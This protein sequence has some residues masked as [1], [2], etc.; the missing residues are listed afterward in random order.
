[1]TARLTAL[2]VVLASVTS[3]HCVVKPDGCD[4]AACTGA[5]STSGDANTTGEGE[6][7]GDGDG[8]GDGGSAITNP[9]PESGDDADPSTGSTGSSGSDE[10]SDDGNEDG[11]STGTTTGEPVDNM[12]APC[13]DDAECTSGVCRSGFCTAVCWTQVDGETPCPAAPP[14]PTA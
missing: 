12:Y 11:S 10:D 8:D 7:D 9:A 2:G 5:G 6:A 3:A 1:M 13:T 4:D 14:M